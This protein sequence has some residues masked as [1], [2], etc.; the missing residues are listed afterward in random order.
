MV[1][2]CAPS[3]QVQRGAR[4]APSSQPTVTVPSRPIAP[5][6]E[7]RAV[8][9]EVPYDDRVNMAKWLGYR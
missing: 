5:S 6:Q 8:N 4:S 1:G 7:P 3:P 9:A 2:G